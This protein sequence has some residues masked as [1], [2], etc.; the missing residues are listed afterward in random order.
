MNISMQNKNLLAILAIVSILTASLLVVSLVSNS[1]NNAEETRTKIENVGADSISTQDDD[2]Q[3]AHIEGL[4]FE[5]PSFVKNLTVVKTD[6]SIS[7]TADIEKETDV[8]LI[9]GEDYSDRIFP[10][11]L[12]KICGNPESDAPCEIQTNNNNNNIEYL[13]VKLPSDTETLNTLY[14]FSQK[15]GFDHIMLSDNYELKENVNPKITETIE[16]IVATMDIQETEQNDIKIGHAGEMTFEY[17]SFVKN[18]EVTETDHDISVRA[19]VEETED[20]LILHVKK[21]N[22]ADY[23]SGILDFGTNIVTDGKVSCDEIDFNGSE[24]CKV[25]NNDRGTEYAVVDV[26]NTWQHPEVMD[27]VYIFSHPSEELIYV[28]LSDSYGMKDGVATEV[29]ETIERIVATLTFDELS[30]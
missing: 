24:E 10:K 5:Y 9:E 30:K 1:Q 27:K 25:I 7:I 16:K 11:G 21:P 17:P 19:D 18:L 8:L 12:A 15:E 4:T 22:Y 14:V 6:H 3:I 20:V 28:T 29:T 13:I 2:S 23:G 26:L